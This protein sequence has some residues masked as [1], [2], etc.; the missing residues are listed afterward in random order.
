[1][2]PRRIAADDRVCAPRPERAGLV[3]LSRGRPVQ[4][5]LDD[6]PGLLDAVAAGEE[7]VIAAERGVEQPLV[8]LGRDPKFVSEPQIQVHR[9][10][11]S[12][13]RRLGLQDKLQPRF[14]I[15]P[16]DELVRL[17]P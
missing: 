3:G 16:Q 15:Y 8:G 9:P 5:R 14:G 12:A 2:P 7:P 6:A 10:A 11:G 13:L 1:M 4:Q 17:G